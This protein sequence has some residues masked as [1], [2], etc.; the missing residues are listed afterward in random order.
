MKDEIINHLIEALLYL[1]P[2]DDNEITKK[3]ILAAIKL[4]VTL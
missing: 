1:N 2:E 3:E 4:L